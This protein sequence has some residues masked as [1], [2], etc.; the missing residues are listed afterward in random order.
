MPT[1]KHL[2]SS[3]VV[4]RSFRFLP[5]LWLPLLALLCLASAWR[6]LGGGDDVWAHAAIG[7]WMVSH[8]TIPRETL[9]LWGAPPQPWIY[10]SWLSQLT[11]YG[12]LSRGEITGAFLLLGLTALIAFLVFALLW[13]A[14]SA[15][16]GG[17]SFWMPLVF[18]LA[19]YCSSLRFRPR[20]ELFTALF[21]TLLLL[22]LRREKSPQQNESR[23][24]PGV[25]WLE[26]F[27]VFA[28]FVVWANF[29]GAVAIGLLLLG[30]TA[31]CEMAQE[32]GARASW[33][34]VWLFMVGVLAVNV[35]PYGFEYWQ[36]LK[37]VGG[38]MFERIDEWKPF[39]KPPFLNS[40]MLLGELILVWLAL[41]CWLGNTRRRWAQLLWLVLMAALF[42]EAR[43]HLWLLPI[44]CLAVI[45]ANASTLCQLRLRGQVSPF[46][47][48]A[49]RLVATGVLLLAVVF[50][51]SPAQ[52]S[53]AQFRTGPLAPTTPRRAASFFKAQHLGAR[54]RVFN[55]YENS[56]FLQWRFGGAPPL[57]IDLLNAYPDSLLF[58]YFDVVNAN[59]RGRKILE[60]RKV[61]VVILRAYA[62]DSSLAKLAK[63][64]D[65][66]KQQ[67]RRIYSATDGTIWLRRP[68]AVT[69]LP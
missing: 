21:L 54:G 18:A 61:N 55:D 35:N 44:V 19:V 7:R 16:S 62:P 48:G 20:P 14:W 22:F 2:I 41:L 5:R 60:A 26:T 65:K 36:A 68:G 29:H 11:F 28:L 15:R 64:L 8:A 38:P 67:W 58:D 10:H 53:S 17:A 40:N 42:I 6:P 23:A 46:A 57:F 9:F 43:R 25:L 39:W 50:T 1:A 49:V 45:A 34:W 24:A 66:N 32:R 13:R 37:P 47:R 4:E 27:F 69:T 63:Y 12:L 59:A 56:S 30:A 3:S 51:V 33:K 31:V 52:F